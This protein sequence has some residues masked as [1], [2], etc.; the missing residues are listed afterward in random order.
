M[1]DNMRNYKYI[2]LLLV[3]CINAYAAESRWMN[4]AKISNVDAELDE[5]SV[6][7][8]NEHTE[9]TFR[10]TYTAPQQSKKSG[11]SFQSAEVKTFFN[12]KEKTFLPYQRREFS[13]QQGQGELVG[14]TTL[15]KFQWKPVPIVL[16]SMNEIMYTRVCMYTKVAG[17]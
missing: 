8:K 17:E 3:Y 5:N 2:I 14:I 12:C 13:G 1:M 9:A 4:V 10:F 16:G 11:V 6:V 7:E 15:P